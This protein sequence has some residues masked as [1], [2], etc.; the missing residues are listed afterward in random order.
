MAE[1]YLT[2]A[3]EKASQSASS[4]SER[5]SLASCKEIYPRFVP[6]NMEDYLRTVDEDDL[7][8]SVLTTQSILCRQGSSAEDGLDILDD[9]ASLDSC[10]AGFWDPNESA[11][12][13][14]DEDLFGRLNLGYH[15]LRQRG[16]EKEDPEKELLE[17]DM[18][19]ESSG[20]N[21]DDTVTPEE[22][23]MTQIDIVPWD[24]T[25]TENGA[26]YFDADDFFEGED[27][28]MLIYERVEEID[29][30]GA[31]LDD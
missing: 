16:D 22:A 28:E 29:K 10:Y 24:P 30:S 4:S 18:L 26:R 14:D 2:Q 13:F 15:Y 20:W 19:F 21:S 25:A 5:L 17:E 8:G 12:Y 3:F 27:A 7:D 23:A 1:K 6:R 9:E 11:Q 31:L